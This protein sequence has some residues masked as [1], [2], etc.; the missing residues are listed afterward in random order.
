MKDLL[1]FCDQ[2]QLHSTRREDGEK[3]MPEDHH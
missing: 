1:P 2:V 3:M